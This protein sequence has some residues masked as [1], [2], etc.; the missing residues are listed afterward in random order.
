MRKKNLAPDSPIAK[1]LQIAIQAT[2]LFQIVSTALYFN[3]YFTNPLVNKFLLGQILAATAWCFYLIQSFLD[4][5]WV[6]VYSPYYAPALIF[7]L[8]AGFRSFTATTP[9]ARV[10][11]FIFATLV[12]TFPLWI[13][14]FRDSRFRRLYAWAVFFAGFCLALGCLRQLATDKPAFDWPFFNA[15]TLSSGSYERQKLG[16]FLGHNNACS[17]Y[18]W[19]SVLY[20]TALAY[21]FRR[22]LGVAGFG[23]F[24]LTALVLIYLGG[25]RGAVLMIPPSLLL[26]FYAWWLGKKSGKDISNKNQPDESPQPVPTQERPVGPPQR[27]LITGAVLVF[28][29]IFLGVWVSQ[30]PLAQKKVQGIFSRFFTSKETLLS[31]TYPRC[32]WMSFLMA[33][34]HPI[35]GVGFSA[36]PFLYPDVQERWFAEHPQTLI[37]LPELNKHAQQAHNDYLQAWAELGL[38]GLLYIFWLLVVHVKCLAQFFRSRPVSILGATAA[39]ATLATLTRACFAFPF[40]EAA[41]SC[42]FLGNWGLFSWYVSHREIVGSPDWIAS[43]L[44]K[45]HLWL[46]ALAV[47]VYLVVTLPI[48]NYIVGDYTAQN[49]YN[50][51]RWGEDAQRAG[52]AVSAQRYFDQGYPYLVKSLKYL[53]SDGLNL[54]TL[55]NETYTRAKAAK[56]ESLFL[57]GIDYLKRSLQTYRYYDTYGHLG[58]AYRLLWEM[59]PKPEYLAESLKYFKKAVGIMPIFDEGWVQIGLLYAKS[60]QEQEALNGLINTKLRFPGFV[61]N[62]LIP[63]AAEAENQK[64]IETA[65]LLLN[66]ASAV[67]PESERVFRETIAFYLRINRLDMATRIFTQLAGHQPPQAMMEMMNRILLVRLQRKEWEEAYRMMSDLRQTPSLQQNPS[68]GY[69]A[70]LVAWLSGRPWDSLA[71]WEQ[72]LE[73]GVAREQ[74]EQPLAAAAGLVLVPL[75]IP[76]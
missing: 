23:V 49:Y 34:D 51:I 15:M 47:P 60:G 52:D 9:E 40:H 50:C 25:S 37:G 36:W 26:L 5:R 13:V 3:G 66:L 10:N 72:A 20:A 53:P 67:S 57:Q 73:A 48:D 8:W 30:L 4:R 21:R 17:A 54:Y 76:W 63:A 33:R 14:S 18:L 75:G 58:R 68:V 31:G 69:Y 62:A 61:E 41:D 38:P 71:C 42:L 39:A 55:G 64:E 46:A 74:L 11:F 24:I 16:S 22:S 65:A 28:T 12:S 1:P 32:W 43:P 2:L 59:T 70:G 29:L 56:D 45:N 27:T 35:A 6:F 7:M 44:R 19:V